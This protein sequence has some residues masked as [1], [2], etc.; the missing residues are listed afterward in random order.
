MKASRRAAV[1]FAAAALVTSTAAVRAEHGAGFKSQFP[2]PS[3]TGPPIKW[4]TDLNADEMSWTVDSPGVGRADFVLERETMKFS[5]TVTYDKLTSAATKV[6][7]HGPQTPGGEA[8]VLIDLGGK[9]LSSPVV[10]EA[11]IN[12]GQ[13][14]YLVTDRFYIQIATKKNEKGE[15]RGQLRR[16]R[17]VASN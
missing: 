15:I 2:D 16:L 17:P 5:W 6:A 12:D 4:T 8:G 3:L 10:G 11:V 1:V 7:I 9:G 13:L 14:R